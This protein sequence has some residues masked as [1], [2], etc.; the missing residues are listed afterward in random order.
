MWELSCPAGACAPCSG[1][2]RL[3]AAWFL[4]GAGCAAGRRARRRPRPWYTCTSYLVHGSRFWVRFFG[5]WSAQGCVRTARCGFCLALVVKY[6]SS[7]LFSCFLR[8]KKLAQ[9]FCKLATPKD[10]K[11]LRNTAPALHRPQ[12]PWCPCSK[13]TPLLYCSAPLRRPPSAQR[14]TASSG[15]PQAA[16]R[17]GSPQLALR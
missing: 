8:R 10:S 12:R 6:G 3:V 13:S 17:N 2:L 7:R 15:H 14:L 11:A 4:R 9:R 16:L 5:S 1:A